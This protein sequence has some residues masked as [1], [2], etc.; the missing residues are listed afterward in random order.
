M[1]VSNRVIVLDAG[2]VIANGAPA[3]VVLDPR[4]IE[5]YLGQESIER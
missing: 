2:A 5:A 1:K 3:D 4:V